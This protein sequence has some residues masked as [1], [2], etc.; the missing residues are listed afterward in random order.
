MASDVG[1]LMPSIELIVIAWGVTAV[2]LIL[3]VVNFAGIP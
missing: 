2:V 1:K 3:I